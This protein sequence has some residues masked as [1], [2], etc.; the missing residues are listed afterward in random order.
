MSG[1]VNDI[2]PEDVAAF[3]AAQR[4]AA[5]LAQRLI[6]YERNDDP[7]VSRNTTVPR[8]TPIRLIRPTAEP[9]QLGFDVEGCKRHN[10]FVGSLGQSGEV[11]R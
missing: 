6:K 7:M 1:V 4:D 8:I 2:S 11:Q 3:R 9:M 10:E 5:S